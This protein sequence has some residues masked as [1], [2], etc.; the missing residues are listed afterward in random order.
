[1]FILPMLFG[2]FRPPRPENRIWCDTHLM[3]TGTSF[4]CT[5]IIFHP[6]VCARSLSSGLIVAPENSDVG[7]GHSKMLASSWLSVPG[8]DRGGPARCG[9][10]VEKAPNSMG[11]IAPSGSFDSAPQALCHA[12]N[13]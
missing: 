5:V 9:S 7:A 8:K 3:V 4:S 2:A 11:K 13:L 1:V 10:V 6:Q 12:I